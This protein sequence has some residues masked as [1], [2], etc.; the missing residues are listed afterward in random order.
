MLLPAVSRERLQAALLERVLAAE[1]VAWPEVLRE[2]LPGAVR[3]ARPAVQR[4]QQPAAVQDVLPEERREQ[5]VAEP[6]G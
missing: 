1:P 5:P 4:E 3:D 2:P 6:D